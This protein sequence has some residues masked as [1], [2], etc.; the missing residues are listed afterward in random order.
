M[1]ATDF[2][3]AGLFGVDVLVVISTAWLA[4]CACGHARRGIL[5]PAI[6]G[7]LAAATIVIAAGALL[8]AT[9]GF[10]PRGFLLLHL[11]AAGAVA[12]LRRRVLRGDFQAALAWLR[13]ARAWFVQPGAARALSLALLI[14]LVGLTVISAWVQPAVL[15]AV[16]Y[17]LPRLAHWMQV[18]RIDAIGSADSRM[19]FVAG[20]WEIA[21]AWILGA[22]TDGYRPF[23]LVQAFAGWLTVAATI[24]LARET[25]L[26]RIG[27]LMA[28]ALVFAMA[29]VVIQFT[30]AQTDLLTAGTFA[31][32]FYLWLRALRRKAVPILG[33]LGVGVS[34]AVKGTVFYIAPA[35]LAWMTWFAWQH[36]LS[37]RQ[38]VWS[39]CIGV[40]GIAAVAGPGFILNLRTY[41]T[42]FGPREMVAKHHR[43]FHS[44]GDLMDKLRWNIA[45][46]LAQNFEPHAQPWPFRET[47]RQAGLAVAQMLPSNDPYALDGIDR[48][49]TVTAVLN[50]RLPDP[51]ITAFGWMVPLLFGIGIV[52]ASVRWRE[53]SA[54]LTL[55]WAAGVIVFGL[56]FHGMHQWH[57]YAFRYQ[58]LIAPW[59][60]IVS[61]WS[62]DRLQKRLR[63]AVWTAVILAAAN[64][65]LHLTFASPLSGWRSV[66]SPENSLNYFVLREWKDWS[67]KLDGPL[68][69]ALPEQRPLAAFYRQAFDRNVT[70]AS[71]AALSALNAEELAPAAGWVVVP[72]TRFIG[73]EGRV[74]GRTWLFAGDERH[75]MSIAAYRRLGAEETMTP[76]L[77]RHL[78]T[79]T[80]EGI[81]HELIVRTWDAS[82]VRFAIRHELGAAGSV[83]VTTSAGTETHEFARGRE[84]HVEVS[85]LKDTLSQVAITVRGRTSNATRVELLP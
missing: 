79:Q 61:A 17:R 62:L 56:F 38:W 68:L 42:A 78:R 85:L 67:S 5:E 65:T 10:G 53:T 43:G 41:G 52:T 27:A 51:D 80:G 16:T 1:S 54:R 9:G 72:A 77:Y 36:R 31:A 32:S 84:T 13:D 15:D 11:A 69:L 8:G 18:G 60:A 3:R 76:I 28:G 46:S 50:Q 55:I 34:L 4:V 39:L 81:R 58:V 24:G 83:V 25:G 14:I 29:N 70:Y 48:R 12:L 26:S 40:V 71:A 7:M 57:Q 2:V 21:V 47:A 35:A 82:P 63:L 75:P 6:A 37:V 59:L 44:S 19:T 22:T 73:R 74:A 33:C 20:G 45:S 49:R 23:G 30:A 66:I 64:L